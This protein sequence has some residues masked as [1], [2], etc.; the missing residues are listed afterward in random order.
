MILTFL[1]EAATAR[2]PAS[3]LA[4]REPKTS[5][6]ESYGLKLRFDKRPLSC[7]LREGKP[8]WRGALKRSAKIRRWMLLSDFQRATKK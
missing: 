1:F 8:L 2:A 7:Y 3:E 5:D 4:A 6:W